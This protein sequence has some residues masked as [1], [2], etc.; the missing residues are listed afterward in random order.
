MWIHLSE[1]TDCTTARNLWNTEV[2]IC[3]CRFGSIVIATISGQNIGFISAP[4]KNCVSFSEGSFCSTLSTPQR[5][6]KKVPMLSLNQKILSL[7]FDSWVKS[8]V[9]PGIC[10]FILRNI[11]KPPLLGSRFLLPDVIKK[12][13]L[14]SQ[15]FLSKNFLLISWGVGHVIV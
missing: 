14:L 9:S 13:Q 8:L 12:F 3:E 10:S 1:E 7:G 11:F 15:P 2:W 5:R 4:N 6:D